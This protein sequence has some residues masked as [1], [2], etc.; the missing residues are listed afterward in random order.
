M[1]RANDASS[2]HRSALPGGTRL[3]NYVLER[4]L[5][6][7]GFGITYMARE[8]VTGR[9]VAIKEYLPSALAVRVRDGLT[10]QPVSEGTRPDFEWGLTR[11]RQEAKLLLSLRH[12]NIV[13]SLNYFESNGTAYLVMEYQE[14]QTLTQLMSGGS[15]L[16]ESEVR[17]FL[18]GLLDGVEAVHKGGLLHRDIKPDNIFIRRDG[19]PVLIDFGAARQAVTRQ[20]RGLTAIVTEGYAPYEQYETDSHQGP[21]TDIYALGA[22]L[23]H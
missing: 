5:G 2:E 18:D 7:G 21:W 9:A 22:V 16:E 11:F 3:H 8:D 19:T 15:V 23:Y 13:P 4:V 1:S 14:G 6:A 10:V 20:S 17:E 12:P